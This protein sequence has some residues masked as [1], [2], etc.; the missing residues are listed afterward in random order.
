MWIV[1]HSKL[2]MAYI[3]TS[4][5][6]PSFP[7]AIQS[8][9]TSL[10][11]PTFSN[12]NLYFSW[13]NHHFSTPNPI[14]S[15]F[16]H[17]KIT[18]LNPIFPLLNHPICSTPPEPPAR[19]ASA[20][21]L[22]AR[23]KSALLPG[24]CAP[25][26]NPHSSGIFQLAIHVKH[27][28]LCVFFW[29]IS[30]NHRIFKILHCQFLFLKPIYFLSKNKHLLSWYLGW[31]LACRSSIVCRV[32]VVRSNNSNSQ[33]SFKAQSLLTSLDFTGYWLQIGGQVVWAVLVAKRKGW[34]RFF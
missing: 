5:I 21:P 16:F 10:F 33:A 17:G 28:G 27:L 29:M 26:R 12:A 34:R 23:L 31:V 14:K 13:W 32:V 1:N 18:H 24:W 4:D 7:I 19:V 2:S 30:K 25:G 20:V 8:H 22:W 3:Q 15:Q 11:E 9:Q 6:P